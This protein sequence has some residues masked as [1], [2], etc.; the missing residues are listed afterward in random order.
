MGPVQQI[1]NCA[2]VTLNDV[3]MALCAGALRGWLVRHRALPV[4]P[5]L[6]GVPVST[7]TDEHTATQGNQLSKIVAPLPTN[8]SDPGERLGAVHAAMEAAKGRFHSMPTDFLT[9]VAACMVPLVANQISRLAG[10]L[11]L[12]EHFRPL[13]LFVSNVPGPPLEMYLGGARLDAIYP[14]ST[15]ADGQGLNITVMGSASKLTVGILADPAQVTDV[16]AIRDALIDELGLLHTAVVGS[17]IGESPATMPLPNYAAARPRRGADDGN[18]TRVF[19]L[20]S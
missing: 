4:G 12:L 8:L 20:G 15:I 2:G 19:S 10:R 3:V 17:S 1:Q 5:L 6:A 13:N 14:I 11:R 18:R 9:D 16:E 7:R